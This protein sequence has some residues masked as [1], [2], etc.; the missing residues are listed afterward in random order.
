MNKIL[1]KTNKN[2]IIYVETKKIKRK[3]NKNLDTRK[4]DSNPSPY[5]DLED[6]P[7]PLIIAEMEKLRNKIS[8][9]RGGYR[10]NY[11]KYIVDAYKNTI[12]LK[13]DTD[14]GWELET[15]PEWEKF[16]AKGR[17][18]KDPSSLLVTVLNYLFGNQTRLKRKKTS[19][20]KRAL[21]PYFLLDCSPTI[22]RD[23]IMKG[24]IPNLIK[25]QPLI[26]GAA[27]QT[28][29]PP[30]KNFPEQNITFIL[31]TDKFYEDIIDLDKGALIH[32]KLKITKKIAGKIFMEMLS[33]KETDN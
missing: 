18:K 8:S 6:L 29:R 16:S 11:R 17:T 2:R 32:T 19:K 5:I 9:E 12:L 10:E 24:G 20:I 7:R 27:T 30:K 22:V 1:S 26:E 25:N 13:Q 21:E 28:K 14:M 33:L 15:H 4:I 23:L 31:K 3:P